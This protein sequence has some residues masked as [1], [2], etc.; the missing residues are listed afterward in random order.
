MW[1]WDPQKRKVSGR[2]D[3]RMRFQLLKFQNRF[4]AWRR[5]VIQI[6]TW[7]TLT[8]MSEDIKL[9]FERASDVK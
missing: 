8:E 6:P 7:D 1:Q 5:H 9:A 2:H 4:I 3:S